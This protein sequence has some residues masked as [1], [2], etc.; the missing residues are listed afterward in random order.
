MSELDDAL[1][2]LST[3][4]GKKSADLTPEQRKDIAAARAVVRRITKLTKTAKRGVG[5]HSG[6]RRSA[7]KRRKPT[8]AEIVAPPAASP[9]PKKLVH[10]I[11]KRPA[12]PG[13]DG[14]PQKLQKTGDAFTTKKLINVSSAP[15]EWLYRTNVLVDRVGRAA[16]DRALKSATAASS[17]RWEAGVRARQDFEGETVVAL[18]S[19]DPAAIGGGGGGAGR[20]VSDYS[21]DC[22]NSVGRL[23]DMMPVDDMRV[24]ERVVH[25]DEWLWLS[26]PPK[27][28]GPIFEAIRRALDYAALRYG[29]MTPESFA[30]RWPFA[31]VLDKIVGPK[32]GE[33]RERTE[34]RKERQAAMAIIKQLSQDLAKFVPD[35]WVTLTATVRRDGDK[36]VI[37]SPI[38]VPLE[39][40]EA[41]KRAT[42]DAAARSH[43]LNQ[44]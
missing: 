22:I 38:F 26:T 18:Q 12:E 10:Y 7:G 20:P 8:E 28:R 21:I 9:P 4:K 39:E 17:R 27:K 6:P 1:S 2:V 37:E 40:P 43:G 36:I 35:E 32:V 30:D 5:S 24:L 31:P 29:M 34:K 11:K 3:F 33:A 15:L 25:Q 16:D 19:V 23:R 14:R 41:E 42:A 13:R 44:T